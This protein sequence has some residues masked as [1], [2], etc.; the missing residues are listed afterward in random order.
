MLPGG[1]ATVQN[2]CFGMPDG[3]RGGFFLLSVLEPRQRNVLTPESA[4]RNN[5]RQSASIRY[6]TKLD[7]D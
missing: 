1:G 2:Y 7:K 3:D 4:P 5:P 6:V